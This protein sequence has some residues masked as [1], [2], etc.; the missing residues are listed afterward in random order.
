MRRAF[1]SGLREGGEKDARLGLARARCTARWSATIVLP[2]RPTRPRAPGRRSALDPL[3]LL[4][5]EEDGPLLP[6]ELE[7][8]LQ[9]LDVRHDAEAALRVRVLERVGR[10]RRGRHAR[11]PAGGQLQQ[12]LRSLA[13]QA[14]RQSEQRPRRPGARRQPL[15]GHA[16]AEQL[17]VGRSANSGALRPA[18]SVRLDVRRGR[19]SPCTVSRIS[20]SCAAPVVGCVS[21]LRR[22]AHAYAWS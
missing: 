7:G 2:V 10:R 9:L 19:R 13:G 18:G 3:T 11:R 8:A 1:A 14:V 12:R 6:G 4:G 16:V 20:T 22:S 15:G 21:S 17:L 5:V